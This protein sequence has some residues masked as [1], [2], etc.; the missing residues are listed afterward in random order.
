MA[1]IGSGD[2]GVYAMASPALEFA[3]EDV[4]VVAVPG[5]TAALAASALLGAPLGHDH[6]YL[7]LSDLHTPWAVIERRL[8]AA[9]EAD[10]VVCLYNPRS[11]RR[12]RQLP[13]ALRILG[14]HRPSDT[15]IGLVREASRAREEVQV[16]TL[17]TIDP[18]D[19]DMNTVVIVGA[20]TTRIVAGRMVTPR[21][22]QWMPR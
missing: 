9:S 16:T 7:S 18:D 14:L 20:S 3:T 5:I 22:Y 21:G 4:E 1:L 8:H 10:L 19:V 13:E 15:P 12:K 11:A 6:V 17:A 2:A